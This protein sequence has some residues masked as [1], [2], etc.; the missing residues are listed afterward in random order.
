[1]RG[2]F[3]GSTCESLLRL[4]MEKWVRVLGDLDLIPE[5][6]GVDLRSTFLQRTSGNVTIVPKLKFR[7]Y[8][9]LISDPSY[10]D[11]ESYILRVQ[12]I[13]ICF[14]IVCPCPYITFGLEAL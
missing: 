5:F 1:M 14:S 6:F 7:D 3:I 10:S 13:V 4:D 12:T 11:L 8:W 2:G 9:R